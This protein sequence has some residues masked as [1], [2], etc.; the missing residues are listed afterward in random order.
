MLTRY[1]KE[2]KEGLARFL[3]ALA[4]AA[5]IGAVVGATGHSPL[6]FW[7]MSVLFTAC[8]ILLTFTW[9]LR[10]PTP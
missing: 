4:T 8:P 5:L 2:Q 10:S 7:E 3:D 6:S 1:S 9:K